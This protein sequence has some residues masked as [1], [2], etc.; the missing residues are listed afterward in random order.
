MVAD[1]E[2][3][4]FFLTEGILDAVPS[5]PSVWAGGCFVPVRTRTYNYTYDA[6]ICMYDYSTQHTAFAYRFTG[7]ERDGSCGPQTTQ[8][9]IWGGQF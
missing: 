9:N 1:D 5:L 2:L 3:Q 4:G 8:H 6:L 7:K